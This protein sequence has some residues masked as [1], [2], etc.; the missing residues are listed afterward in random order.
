MSV[1]PEIRIADVDIFS[2]A[3]LRQVLV[4]W[5]GA[6]QPL[7]PMATVPELFRA[8]AAQHPDATALVVRGRQ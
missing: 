3:E 7:P 4:E 2:E 8:Q 1:R 5:N 6:D